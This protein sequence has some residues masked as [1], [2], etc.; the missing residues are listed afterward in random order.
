MSYRE[1]QRNSLDTQVAIE[2]RRFAVR[3]IREEGAK[4]DSITYWLTWLLDRE[5]TLEECIDMAAE[6]DAASDRD[7]YRPIMREL[8][9]D[10]HNDPVLKVILEELLGEG[11]GASQSERSTQG[12]GPL[13]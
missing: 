3:F 12:K 7:Y 6:V 11:L 4:G 9:D 13:V 5:P 1:R 8:L 2:R 10:W